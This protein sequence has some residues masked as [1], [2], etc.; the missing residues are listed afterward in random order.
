MNMWSTALVMMGLLLAVSLSL[1]YGVRMDA[2]GARSSS[3]TLTACS[4]LP[5]ARILTKGSSGEAMTVCIGPSW[6]L[7]PLNR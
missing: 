7:L 5:S 6:M 2:V 3:T 1:Y 4:G